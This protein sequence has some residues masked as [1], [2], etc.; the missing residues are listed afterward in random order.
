MAFIA[1]TKIKEKQMN[2]CMM[3]SVQALEIIIF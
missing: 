1:K 2:N 3:D